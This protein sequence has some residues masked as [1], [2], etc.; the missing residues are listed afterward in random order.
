[1]SNSSEPKGSTMNDNRTAFGR[2]NP[3]AGERVVST[4]HA[5]SQPEPAVKPGREEIAQVVAA[6]SR[7]G[8]PDFQGDPLVSRH[9]DTADAVLALLPGRAEAEVKAEAL[10][11]YRAGLVAQQLDDYGIVLPDVNQIVDE[12]AVLADELDPDHA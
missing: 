4:A 7:A 11:D 9:Y 2:H 10:R 12:L 1:M 8:H 3:S 6:V 5:P